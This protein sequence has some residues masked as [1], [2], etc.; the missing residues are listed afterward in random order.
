MPLRHV[1]HEREAIL[2][3]RAK[4]RIRQPARHHLLY[5][6]RV[7]HQQYA[8]KHLLKPHIGDGF[9]QFRLIFPPEQRRVQEHIQQPEE[10]LRHQPARS[11]PRGTASP[12]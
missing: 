11:P 12:A 5:Q 3:D 6:L 8:E 2:I 1:P 7:V 9:R 10:R 4:H